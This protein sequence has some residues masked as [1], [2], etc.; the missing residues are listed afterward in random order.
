MEKYTA[1][2]I[3]RAFERLG[4]EKERQRMQTN[5]SARKARDRMIKRMGSG[6]ANAKVD[7]ATSATDRIPLWS[8]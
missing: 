3:D 8:R 6:K 4:R 5:S 2:D 7:E 1:E